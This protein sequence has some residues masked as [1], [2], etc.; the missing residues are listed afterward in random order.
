[1]F[2]SAPQPVARMNTT[3]TDRALWPRAVMAT[4]LLMI[5]SLTAHLVDITWF[6]GTNQGAAAAEATLAHADPTPH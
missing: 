2:P 5:L 3:R 6:D 4:L 1:M